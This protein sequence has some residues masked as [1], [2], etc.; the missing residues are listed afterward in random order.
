MVCM[1]YYTSNKNMVVIIHPR[2]NLNLSLITKWV[3]NHTWNWPN[4]SWYAY[5]NTLYVI[6]KCPIVWCEGITLYKAA[7][8]MTLCLICNQSHWELLMLVK[9]PSL[10][11][12][13]CLCTLR[14][15]APYSVTL[16]VHIPALGKAVIWMFKCL[17]VDKEEITVFF[18]R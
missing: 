9:I 4:I 7:I 12:T 15:Y 3:Y 13:N 14:P 10:Q 1:S 17:A 6:R 5:V 2:H 11:W 8:N 16:L 18:P